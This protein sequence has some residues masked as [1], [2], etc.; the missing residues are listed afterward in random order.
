MAEK[1]HVV[2]DNLNM[3][4]DGKDK[5]WTKFDEARGGKFEF[6]DTPIHATWVNQVGIFFSILQRNVIRH[7]SFHSAQESM[8]RIMA[9]LERWNGEAGHPFRWTFRGYPMQKEAS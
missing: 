5:R 6:H 2:W 8:D 3:H 9:F 7:G 4:D 1:I